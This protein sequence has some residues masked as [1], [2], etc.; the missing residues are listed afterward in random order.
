M[1]R[2]LIIDDDPFFSEFM[3]QALSARA[4]EAALARDG[5]EG[6][7]LFQGGA[8]DVVVCDLV[9]PDQEGIQTIRRMR[10]T[11]PN[12]AI[13]AVSGG[14]SQPAGANVDYLAAAKHLGAD[15]T[16]KKPFLPSALTR[17]VD[18]A[19]DLRRNAQGAST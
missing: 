7:R 13:V 6:E 15:V 3:R 18:D 8:Y 16:L 5:R 10:A 19:L 11:N 4:H 2:V 12:V 9:M 17:A 1:A 14:V